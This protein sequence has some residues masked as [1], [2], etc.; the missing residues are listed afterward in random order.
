MV[1]VSTRADER[2]GVGSLV[3][4]H[5][6]RVAGWRV[7][8]RPGIEDHALLEM[9]AVER[10]ALLGFSV[11]SLDGLDALSPL[12]G[13]LRAKSRNADLRVTIGGAAALASPPRA[14]A[15]G[16]DFVARDG[17]DA[18]RLARAYLSSGVGAEMIDGIEAQ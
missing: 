3:V 8:E 4:A 15:A 17:R 9:V 14:M 7:R 10:V 16:A 18:A 6:F 1:V 13:A 11:G 5:D 2:H 12:I